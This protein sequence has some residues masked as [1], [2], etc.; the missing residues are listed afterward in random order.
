KERGIFACPAVIESKQ[1]FNTITGDIYILRDSEMEREKEK[2]KKQF[3]FF[4]VHLCSEISAIRQ[5]ST[6]GLS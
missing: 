2:E 6:V 1:S 4:F 3:L 5:S